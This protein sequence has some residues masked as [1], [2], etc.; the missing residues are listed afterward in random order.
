MPF[1]VIDSTPGYMPEEM[2]PSRF[3]TKSEAVRFALELAQEYRELGHRIRRHRMQW[4]CEQSR[5]DP[6]RLVEVLE[7]PEVRILTSG[8]E[9]S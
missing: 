8:E 7:V 9:G 5:R 6:G 2:E 3:R 1:L 4:F